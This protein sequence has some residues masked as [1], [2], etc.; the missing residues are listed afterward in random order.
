MQ[1]DRQRHTNRHK[2]MQRD[3]EKRTDRETMQT[4]RDRQWAGRRQPRAEELARLSLAGILTGSPGR[5]ATALAA[6]PVRAA[7]PR[8]HTPRQPASMRHTYLGTQRECREPGRH[9]CVRTQ[10]VRSAGIGRTRKAA[11]LP[12]SHGQDRPR[13][14][15]AMQ[16][17]AADKKRSQ[18]AQTGTHMRI[19]SQFITCTFPCSQHRHECTPDS[20]AL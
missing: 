2:H 3:R 13:R 9:V 10:S 1:T 18:A 20:Q 16:S 14:Q 7:A 6:P 19:H 8:A 4:Q 5:Q 12:G 11:S 17:A 15:S